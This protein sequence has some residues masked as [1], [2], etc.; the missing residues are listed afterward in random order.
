[1]ASY[2]GFDT[3]AYGTIGGGLPWGNGAGS[4]A[5]GMA[6]A[7]SGNVGGVAQAYQQSYNNS[8]AMNQ[9][10]YNNIMAGYQQTL[11][12]HTTAQQAIQAGYANLY[13]EV[14]AKVSGI[15]QARSN[16]INADSSRFLA[17]GSQQLIDRGLGNTTIQSSLNRG[18]ESDRN[19]RQLELSD[20][21]AQMV[22]GYM[23]QIGQAG[24]QNQQ[25]GLEDSTGL[26]KSQLDWMNSMTSKYPDA[27]LYASLA[28]QAGQNAGQQG[29]PVGSYG[30][31]SF[32][33]APG[34][35][36]G[37]VPQGQPYYGGG[38]G[39]GADIGGGGGGSWM[40]DQYNSPSTAN[41]GYG[42]WGGGGMGVGGQVA[43]QIPELQGAGA[44]ISGGWGDYGGYADYGGGGDF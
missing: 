41:Y 24:L 2:P 34:P 28:Q 44:A 13:N 36:V 17:K 12:Q 32:A 10:Q 26:A 43:G 23:S 9:S 11:A 8:L 15:G 27:G 42:N 4:G 3:P 20:S 6:A 29:A 21:L 7:A 18:V 5:S 37:Y 16:A 22:G 1:M 25:R 19:A 33:G 14:I 30:G 38:G 40:L 31:G 39:M 35:K